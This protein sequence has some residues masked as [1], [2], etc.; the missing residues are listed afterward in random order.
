VKT[1]KLGEIIFDPYIFLQFFRSSRYEDICILQTRLFSA[2]YHAAGIRV[3]KVLA[4]L[5]CS[6][7]QCQFNDIITYISGLPRSLQTPPTH[8]VLQWNIYI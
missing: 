2:Q 7:A 8:T 1:E 6:P 4:H 5:L 3:N